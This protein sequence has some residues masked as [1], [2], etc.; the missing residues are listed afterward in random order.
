MRATNGFQLNPIARPPSSGGPGMF[1]DS[2]G[3]QKV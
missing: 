3:Q 1:P 2:I